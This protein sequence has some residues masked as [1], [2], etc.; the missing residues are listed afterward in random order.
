MKFSDGYWMMRDGVVARHPVEVH[1][2]E[3]TAS[4][5]TVFAATA[6]VAHRGDTLNAPLVTISCRA[7][8]DDVIGVRITH[9]LGGQPRTP[10]FEITADPAASVR[11]ERAADAVTF[12]SGRLAVSFATVGDWGMSLTADGRTLTSSPHKAAA[13]LDVSR[14]EMSEAD[15]DRISHLI[16]QARE[17]GR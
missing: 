14:S 12:C 1:D 5:L 10:N 7:P 13:L 8:M 2:V 3:T 15:L 4:G 16:D 6:H 11:I 9:H 17:E